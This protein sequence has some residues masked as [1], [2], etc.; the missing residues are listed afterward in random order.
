MLIFQPVNEAGTHV[1]AKL[2]G[3]HGYEASAE[4]DEESKRWTC[5]CK[6]QMLATYDGIVDARRWLPRRTA[7]PAHLGPKN[8]GEV[9]A[10][11]TAIQALS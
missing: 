5:Y 10:R 6:K 1:V 9:S 8:L 3:Q 4:Q 2:A 7:A 11:L